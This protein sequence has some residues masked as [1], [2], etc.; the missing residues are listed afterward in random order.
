M[1]PQCSDGDI[2]DVDME[3]NQDSEIEYEIVED[4][5]EHEELG[6]VAFELEVVDPILEQAD[7]EA[8]EPMD[9]VEAEEHEPSKSSSDLL[10]SNLDRIP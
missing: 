1:D 10:G 7:A 2:V 9:I 5:E 8:P 3:D 6:G 4:E